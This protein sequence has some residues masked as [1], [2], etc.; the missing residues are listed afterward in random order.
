[1]KQN[2]LER[3]RRW[4]IW[5]LV[6][7]A[8][9]AVLGILLRYKAA[10]SFPTVNYKYLLNAH[11]HFAFNGWL[12]TVLFTAL[13]YVLAEA[14]GQLSKM[15]SWQF[16][17]NQVSSFGMLV[18]FTIQGY[19]AVSIF[20]SALSVV[21]YLW[22]A[23]TFGRDLRKMVLP[24][25]VKTC[26]QAALFFLLLSSAG[27]LLL[28][29]SMSHALGDRDFYYNAIYLYLHFQYNGWFTFGVLALF[30]FSASRAGI[31]L[32]ERGT[33]WFIGLM[34]GSCVPAYTMSL[35]W[36][37]PAGWIWVVAGLAGLAQWV[38]L[39][40]LTVSLWRSRG[41]WRRS[42]AP[43]ERLLWI[44]AYIAFGAKIKLQALSV[45]PFFGRLAFGNRPVIIAYLHLVMLCFV[46]FFILGFLIRVGLLRLRSLLARAGLGLW[47]IGVIGNE[48]VLLVQSLLGLSGAAWEDSPYY[49][50]GAALVIAVG[51]GAM[52]CAA[53]CAEYDLNQER[54]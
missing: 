31:T 4:V 34:V 33:R 30:F 20:F 26:M 13:L 6:N 11:S 21:F 22:F 43:M 35:L 45:I 2:A 52:L 9:V 25:G 50:F 14:G 48:V 17:L 19:G 12:T 3:I 7:L 38:A 10:W 15:Y 8:I 1:M 47:M 18:S 54:H 44:C 53:W 5:C 29:Y 39:L 23:W 28:G 24:Y 32:P 41:Q 42:L 49:L 40:V 16:W 36:T 46:S 27:P 51:I 37:G